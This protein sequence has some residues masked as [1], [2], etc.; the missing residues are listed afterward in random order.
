MTYIFMYLYRLL[1]STVLVICVWITSIVFR[2]GP[3]PMYGQLD[4]EYLLMISSISLLIGTVLTYR[5]GPSLTIIIYIFDI[6]V[7]SC[8]DSIWNLYGYLD[9]YK[10]V[11]YFS[12]YAAA[13]S[14]VV[15]PLSIPLKTSRDSSNFAIII[16]WIAFA[17]IVVLIGFHAMNIGYGM[18][19]SSY[20]QIVFLVLF[21]AEIIRQYRRWNSQCRNSE[22]MA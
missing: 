13:L 21:I 1:I 12:L 2:V 18:I 11:V 5:T 6:I 19:G 7:I 14:I 16:C 3:S 8:L 15:F 20:I 9:D 22:D 17:F 4:G 10:G